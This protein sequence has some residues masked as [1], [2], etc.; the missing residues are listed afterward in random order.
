VRLHSSF[1]DSREW[2]I[3]VPCYL[4]LVVL[5]TYWSYAALVA[6]R[7]PPFQSPRLVT[8]A[9]QLGTLLRSDTYA[10]IPLSDGEPYYWKFADSK[11]IPEAVD[12]PVDLVN[13]VLYPPRRQNLKP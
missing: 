13:R 9:F 11:A 1:A 4:I 6:L 10:N 8:G 7:T 12:L 3:V 5:L 2:A